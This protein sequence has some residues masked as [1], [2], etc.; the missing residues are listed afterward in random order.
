LYI[1]IA[2]SFDAIISIFLNIEKS[3]P[4]QNSEEP[5]ILTKSDAVQYRA[6]G[7]AIPPV[8]MWHTATKVIKILN[9]I[10]AT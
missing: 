5:F 9:E 3:L 7:N 4:T 1:H 8:M 2:P 10:N 6:L